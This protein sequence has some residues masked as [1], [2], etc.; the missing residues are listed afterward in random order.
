M[1]GDFFGLAFGGQSDDT[2]EAVAENT[3]AA[4]YPRLRIENLADTDPKVARELR[5]IALRAVSPLLTDTAPPKSLLMLLSVMSFAVPAARL[6]VPAT[7]SAPVCVM[8]PFA[9][10]VRL[11]EIAEARARQVKG[12]P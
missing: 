4:S 7:E 1:P 6:L 8:A 2:I 9:A 11:P 12:V 5:E 3:V 10:T